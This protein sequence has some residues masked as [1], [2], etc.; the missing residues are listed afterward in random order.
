MLEKKHIDGEYKC[1]I[2]IYALSTCVWCKKTKKFLLDKG[3]SY[4][5]IDVDL[6]DDE[7]EEIVREEIRKYTN[8]SSFPT[9]IIDNKDCVLGFNEERIAEAIENASK[10]Q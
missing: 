6:L 9:I 10:K 7:D 1:D 5:Y 2:L 8:S 4:D 3:V